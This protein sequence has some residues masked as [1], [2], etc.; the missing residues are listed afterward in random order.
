MLLF[1]IVALELLQQGQIDCS[2][3]G[4]ERLVDKK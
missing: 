2:R 4:I 3:L 1:E